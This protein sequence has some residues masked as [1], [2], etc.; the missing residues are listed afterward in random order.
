MAATFAIPGL[1]RQ[2]MSPYHLGTSHL[3]QSAV[4]MFAFVALAILSAVAPFAS[5]V[6]TPSEHVLVPG[7]Y[8]ARSETNFYQV[9]EGGSVSHVEDKVHVLDAAGSVVHIVTPQFATPTK[10]NADAVLPLP[11]GWVAYA[12]WQNSGSDAIAS[13]TTS[14]TVPA[15]PPTDDG[16]TLFY[17]NSIEPTSGNAILQPVLQYGS[18]AAGGGSYWAVATWYLVGNSVMYTNPVR[19]SAGANLNGIITLKSHSGSSYNYVSSFTNVGSTSLT[20]NGAAQLTWATE[21]LEVYSVAS[22]NDFASGSTVFS[23]INLSL[24]SGA[25]P[26][27]KWSTVSSSQDH[28]TTTVNTNG[29][30]N[31]KITITH[32]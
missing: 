21:T 25:V 14:W 32:S 4:T 12:S 31:A 23:N 8:R 13:F 26:S 27:V 24:A 3:T 7:G 10:V 28:L 2:S 19:V 22:Q 18:S 17:F 5:A 6:P 9:P 30:T 20:V 29:A 11:T 1:L 15:V 16:Q